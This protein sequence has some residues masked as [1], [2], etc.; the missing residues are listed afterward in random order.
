MAR[1]PMTP[2]TTTP[3]D[4][5]PWGELLWIADLE[6]CDGPIVSHFQ[7]KSTG[8]DFIYC[9]SD[10]GDVADRWLVWRVSFDT[11]VGLRER[12]IP[13][14]Q[15]IPAKC[16]DDFCCVLEGKAIKKLLL[17]DIPEEYLPGKDAY[18]SGNYPEDK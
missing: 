7:S 11:I 13:L 1:E 9:W 18:L 5:L 4:A 15:V 14:D 2:I 8:D 12:A 16:L 6:Y 3:L 10:C 17:V